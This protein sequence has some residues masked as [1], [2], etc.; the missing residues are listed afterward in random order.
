MLAWLRRRQDQK[1]IVATLY[2]TAL[3]Q[4]RQPE[5]YSVL[6]VPDTVEGRFEVVALHLAALLQ[7]LA[8][9]TPHGARLALALTEH[10]VVDMDDAMRKV[11]V[12]DLAV[13]R[14]VQRAAAALFDRHGAYA[15]ALAAG[16][17]GVA[18]WRAAL[19]RELTPLSAPAIDL[20]RLAGYSAT[21]A[22]HLAALADQ[23]LAAGRVT[24]PKSPT[25]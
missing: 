25:A 15:P 17:D 2:A 18:S 21:L 9:V 22:P 5:F 11:G 4:A 6:G 19:E 1:A 10:F 24:F 3:A 23:D 13:P 16:L 7:R 20:D 14:K 12:G 8:A